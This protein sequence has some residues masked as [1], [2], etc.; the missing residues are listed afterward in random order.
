MT[1]KNKGVPTAERRELYPETVMC[2]C[3]LLALFGFL[4]GVCVG[5]FL[6]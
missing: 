1:S 6:C 3:C 5:W 2:S 4:V